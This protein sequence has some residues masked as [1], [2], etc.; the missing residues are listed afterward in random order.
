[1]NHTALNWTQEHDLAE[2]SEEQAY[3]RWHSIALT[4]AAIAGR[5]VLAGRPL[6]TNAQTWLAEAELAR[7]RHVTLADAA[8][9]TGR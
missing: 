3:E 4:A 9:R 6:D 7:Q 2:L 1:M 5:Q 8:H